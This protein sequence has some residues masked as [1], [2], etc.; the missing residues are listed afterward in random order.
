VERFLKKVEPVERF[1]KKV[2]PVE[3]IER[4]R[5]TFGT[6]KHA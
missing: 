4:N 2:E 5:S 3:R 6:A 1:L